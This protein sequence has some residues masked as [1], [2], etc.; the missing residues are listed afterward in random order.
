VSITS[1]FVA[2]NDKNASVRLIH[3]N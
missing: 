1:C 2:E 3:R